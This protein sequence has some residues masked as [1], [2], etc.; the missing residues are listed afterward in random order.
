L[1]RPRFR[2]VSVPDLIRVFVQANARRLLRRVGRVEQTKVN[3]GGILG[4]EREA[5][6]RAIPRRAERVRLS[7]P[8]S[9]GSLSSSLRM[10]GC[11]AMMRQGCGSSELEMIR[12]GAASAGRAGQ[13]PQY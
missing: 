4:K 5:D 6:A 7:R 10:M 3:G 8:Y 2:Q 13:H 1:A 12:V 9:H 11:L